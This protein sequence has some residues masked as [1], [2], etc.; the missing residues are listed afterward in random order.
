[1]QD[2]LEHLGIVV[3]NQR[4]GLRSGLTQTCTVIEAGNKLETFAFKK[5]SDHTIRAAKTKAPISSAV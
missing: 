5:K 1:M 4:C 2:F 3:R